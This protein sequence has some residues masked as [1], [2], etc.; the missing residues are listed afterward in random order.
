MT[1]QNVLPNNKLGKTRFLNGNSELK[2]H[3]PETA[4]ETKED[5]YEFLQRYKTV[6]VKPNHGTGGH[7][8]MRVKRTSDEGYEYQ[9]GEKVYAFPTYEEMYHSLYRITSKR[10]HLVQ[11]GIRLLKYRGRPFDVRIMVQ[12]NLKGEWENTGIIGRVAHPNKI[13]TNYHSGGTPL[14]MHTLLKPYLTGKQIDEYLVHLNR[15]GREIAEYLVKGY[16]FVTAVGV[17]VG[18]DS[19]FKPWIIEVNTRPDPYIFKKLKD[20]SV[21]RRII[22]YVKAH[23]KASRFSEAAG[24][25]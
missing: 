10:R 14:A 21:F 11:K 9:L 17:D 3:I 20:K 22:R 13:V 1:Y 12:K 16:P 19:K 25:S 23:R 15:L 5:L 6:Y 18:L 2:K 24:G 4:P 8:V 7:G